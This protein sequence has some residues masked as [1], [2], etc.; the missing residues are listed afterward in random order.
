LDGSPLARRA[1]DVALPLAARLDVGVVAL[2][3]AWDTDR[4]SAE[5]IAAGAVEADPKGRVESIVISGTTPTDAIARVAR[6]RSAGVCM[7]SHGRGRLRWAV[8]GSVAESVILESSEPVLLVGHRAE[9]RWDVPSRTVIVAVDGSTASPRAVRAACEWAVAL[10]LEVELEY[11]SHPLDVE[12]AVHPE[13]VLG[14]LAAILE[15]SGLPRRIHHDRSSYAA[16]AIAD[17]AEEPPAALLV[18]ASHGLT[19]FARFALGSV[20]MGVLNV[21]SCP[22][23]V[24]PPSRR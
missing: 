6:E 23:L 19:G 9:P 18:V 7:S 21:A 22:V 3:C 15:E 8:L 16:G 1:L 2:S 20:S 17:R 14:P 4:A 10:D 11:V 5:A 24:V 12:D 13:T